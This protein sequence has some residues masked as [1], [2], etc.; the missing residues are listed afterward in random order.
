MMTTR[1]VVVVND[2]L[3]ATDPAAPWAAYLYRWGDDTLTATPLHTGDGHTPQRAVIDLAM[4][5]AR[6]EEE[7]P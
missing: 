7:T 2:E 4:S 6:H 1:Y 3:R 5:W